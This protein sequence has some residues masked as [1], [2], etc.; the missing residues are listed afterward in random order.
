MRKLCVLIFAV[1]TLA[2]VSGCS[3]GR[4]DASI[5]IIGGADGDLRHGLHALTANIP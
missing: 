1:L 2:C 3:G 5:G 4:H